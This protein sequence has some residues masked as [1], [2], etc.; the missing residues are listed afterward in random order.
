MGDIPD[1]RSPLGKYSRRSCLENFRG[2][3]LAELYALEIGAIWL[4]RN[5]PTA[6]A[7]L[8]VRLISLEIVQHL[9][10]STRGYYLASAGIQVST[11]C[12]VS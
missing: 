7:V 8:F 2:S 6:F 9:M 3:C 10:F 1:L 5:S 12:L 11:N 4:R